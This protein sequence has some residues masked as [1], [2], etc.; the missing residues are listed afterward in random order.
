MDLGW[1]G[2]CVGRVGPGEGV[3]GGGGLF[4]E[5]IAEPAEGD[6]VP[7][8]GVGFVGAPVGGVIA[9]DPGV[10]VGGGDGAQAV[11]GVP[12]VVRGTRLVVNW[13]NYGGLTSRE[14]NGPRHHDGEVWVR[15]G[16]PLAHLAERRARSYILT[17]TAAFAHQGAANGSTG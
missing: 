15:P 5:L 1:G 16:D 7:G 14:R 17:G 8:G 13:T 6:G 4:Q 10:A 9:V 12:L 11:V 2:V 3:A